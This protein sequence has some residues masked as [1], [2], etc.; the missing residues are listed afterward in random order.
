MSLRLFSSFIK[1][2]KNPCIN[3]VNFMNHKYTDPYDEIYYSEIQ[4]GKCSI[5]G[6]QNLVTGEIDYDFA[7]VCR[8]NESKCGNEGRYYYEN[9]T[10]DTTDINKK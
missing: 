6:K 1:R 2:T 7:A 5:F 4:L 3:C 10:T 8:I 9:E